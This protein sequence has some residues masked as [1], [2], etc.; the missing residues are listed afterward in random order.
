MIQ[1]SDSFYAKYEVAQEIEYT[2]KGLQDAL[3]SLAQLHGE[4]IKNNQR[5]N[6]ILKKLE[7][8]EKLLSKIQE[9]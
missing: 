7:I 9:V 3:A 4:E 8:Y 6:R 2:I 1:N 5:Y